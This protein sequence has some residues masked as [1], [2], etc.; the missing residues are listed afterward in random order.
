LVNR[1]LAML[2]GVG[3]NVVSVKPS[4]VDLCVDVLLRDG[5]WT[6]ELMDHA[7]TRA[8]YTAAHEHRRRLTGLSIGRGDVGARLYD[9]PLEIAT[10]SEKWWM[11]EIW[12]ID[13]VPEGHR[14][15]RVEY[16]LRREALK[17]LGI[18]SPIDLWDKAGALWRYCSRQWL[19]FQD[20]AKAH[21][22]QQQTLPWWSIVQDGYAGAQTAAALVRE[23][24]LRVD[25]KQLLCQVHGLLS[26]WIALRKQGFAVNEST[27]QQ[28][29]PY[30]PVLMDA[31]Q[32][33]E[34]TDAELSEKVLRK[35][36]R[37]HRVQ[38]VAVVD[39][40]ESSA[41]AP[42]AVSSSTEGSPQT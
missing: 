28:L 20:D 15:I 40:F 11:Y 30:I 9:K 14:V 19:K 24:A 37:Y 6:R 31:L 38:N 23:K 26:S 36:S 35:L 22:T 34:L 13:Q 7:V 27:A 39:P 2:V 41:L 5:E 10:Q 17:E 16:Q 42:A 12:G 25:E 32:R 21:H 1:I 33:F 29:A 4:R 3:A 18:D 8:S